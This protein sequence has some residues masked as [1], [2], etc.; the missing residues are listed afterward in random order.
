MFVSQL[1]VLAVLIFQVII[2]RREWKRAKETRNLTDEKIRLLEDSGSK[3]ERENRFL[4]ERI[5]ELEAELDDLT[6]EYI[7][8][9]D[10]E[11]DD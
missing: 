9:G 6:V 2:N 3:V 8:R 5:A 7:D 10:S 4:K 11:G 1:F